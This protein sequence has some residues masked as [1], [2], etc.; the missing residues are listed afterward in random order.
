MLALA[1]SGE[2]RDPT[3]TGGNPP[4]IGHGGGGGDGPA[5]GSVLVG[6]WTAEV[7]F[8]LPTDIQRRT[9]TWVFRQDGTCERTVETFSTLEDRTLVD[10]VGCTWDAGAST[11]SIVFDGGPGEVTFNWGLAGF[12]RDR[13][14][15]DGLEYA[16]G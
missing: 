4:D 10:R 3:G 2:Y 9:T 11:V 16:R 1:C 15:L 14:V 5:T 13:L 7:V 12:S 6:E 8:M